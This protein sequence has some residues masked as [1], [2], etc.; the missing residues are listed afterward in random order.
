MRA[1]VGPGEI[2][3]RD[4]D[5]QAELEASGQTEDVAALNRDPDK[6]YEITKD[7]HV[8]IE[9]YLSDTSVKAALEAG[10]ST[11]EI[12]IDALGRMAND[13]KLTPEDYDTARKLAKYKD[14]PNV[15]AQLNA[16]GQRQGFN[17]FNPLDWLITPAHAQ[18]PCMISTAEGTFPISA[19]G[20]ATC[21]ATFAAMTSTAGLV[22]AAAGAILLASTS[23]AGGGKIDETHKLDDGTIVHLTGNGSDLKRTATMSMSDGSKAIL[24]FKLDPT[25]GQ[26]ILSDGTLNGK[27]MARPSL[28]NVIYSMQSGG[29]KNVVLSES[30]GGSGSSN[31][32][33]SAGSAGAAAGAPDPDDE[34]RR[35]TNPKHHQNAESPEPKNADELY[36]NS[37]VDRNG[38]RWAKDSDGVIHRFSKPSNG[39]SHWNG[40]TVGRDP[41]KQQNI[42]N[43]IKKA[44]GYRG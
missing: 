6:A 8:E 34:P 25:T 7:K 38:V 12:V 27:P 42:P 40:S 19:I 2:I 36:R 31:G 33:A 30:A 35:V 37:I 11:V 22:G 9:Y 4:K 32:S 39:E 10:K 18:A 16:C 41:I 23:S 28:Q 43:E 21:R 20:A 15:I 26:L 13:G 17:Q 44:L 3:I 29:V 14:D 1:T 5:K 24:E